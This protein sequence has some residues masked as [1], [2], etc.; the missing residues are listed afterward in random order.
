MQNPT[1]SEAALQLDADDELKAF[2]S[3]F[4]LQ[5]GVLYL[6]GN[7]L[8]LLS[9]PAEA[10]ALRVL[11][12]WKTLGIDGWTQAQPPW[13]EMAERLGAMVAPF[14]GAEPDSV[15]VTNSTTVN[16]HQLLCTLNAK[17][18]SEGAQA[19]SRNVIL[20]DALNF[21]SD[22]FALQS[23][24]K[25]RGIGSLKLAAGNDAYS[26]DEKKLI[27]LMTDEV[28]IAVFPSVLYHSGQLL[29]MELL[30]TEA[31]KRG[32][33]IGFDCSHS[34]GAIP[35]EFDRW[36]V[37]FAFWCHYK[38]MNAGPGASG[39]LYLNRRHFGAKPGLAGW[40]S[41]RKDRQFDLTNE[42]F[43][44]E[45]A[46]GLQIGTPNILSMAP[47]QGSLELMQSAGIERI[48]K[49]SLAMTEYLMTRIDE[50]LACYGVEIVNPRE[51]ARR[52]GHVSM[53][54]PEAIRICKALKAARVIPDFRPPDIIRVSPSAL[55]G[56]FAECEEFIS[57]ARQIL[58]S[59]SY[60]EHIDTRDLIS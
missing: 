53:R 21:S 27:E 29:D 18:H 16:L 37:D 47:L 44:A 51:D 41:S 5:S 14:V 6:D 38:Y 2:R 33:L 19:D 23:H 58:Q 4:Y 12:E 36:G 54:H 48:R 43:S 57:R 13:F 25:L 49:K 20:A 40:F 10:T 60:L 1:A 32:I 24:V 55:Y 17:S 26:L 30:T 59:R 34:I 35:H 39:G 22:Q 46:G 9:K 7:S 8:G 45:T 3:Q 28:R 15:I 50:E 31:R 42:L 56:S 11:D 52:G